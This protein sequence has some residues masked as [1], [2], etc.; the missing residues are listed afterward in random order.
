MNDTSSYWLFSFRYIS[1]GIQKVVNRLAHKYPEFLRQD[2][3]TGGGIKNKA[4]VPLCTQTL[5]FI[6]HPDC[7]TDLK[8]LFCLYAVTGCDF[9]SR[10][11]I[12]LERRIRNELTDAVLW[13]VRSMPL[14]KEK[15]L[16][17]P[18]HHHFY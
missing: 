6:K 15:Q 4:H 11:I 5:N 13:A 1:R 17:L 14:K 16:M 2:M 18:L 7:W 9:C 10:Y 12:A 8:W 3:S